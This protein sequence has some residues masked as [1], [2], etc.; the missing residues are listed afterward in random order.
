MS[1]AFMLAI[2]EVPLGIFSFTSLWWCLL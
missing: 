1:H 2:G